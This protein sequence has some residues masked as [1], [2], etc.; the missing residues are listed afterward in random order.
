MVAAVEMLKKY[1]A[2]KSDTEGLAQIPRTLDTAQ[3]SAFLTEEDDGRIKASLRAS[4]DF[5]I[6]AVAKTF[7]GG[8]HKKAAG[9]TFSG[10]SIDEAEKLIVSELEKL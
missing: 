2:V 9:C 7:G 10:I 8:G 3:L 5:D 1:D 6:E 4:G